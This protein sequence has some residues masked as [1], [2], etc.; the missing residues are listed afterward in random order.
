MYHLP[1]GVGG[2]RPLKSITAILLAAA[3]LPRAAI[4]QQQHADPH[5]R[6][7]LRRAA[8]AGS[9]PIVLVDSAHRNFH[10]LDGG[11]APFGLLLQADGYQ[12]RAGTTAFSAQ[13][14]AGIDLLVIANARSTGSA[15]SAFTPD[16]IAAVR[17]WV[18]DGGSLL[19]IADHAPFGTA[20][21]AMA[22][23]FGVSL[24]TGFAVVRQNGKTTANIE[25]RGR[26][27][28]D[29]PILQG[30]DASERVKAVKSFTGKSMSIPAD[31][32]GLL[33][34]PSDAL[35][36][37]KEADIEALSHGGTVPGMHIGGRAQAIASD[38]GRGRIVVAGEAAMFSEQILP[39]GDRVGLNS[40][41]DQQFVLNLVHWLSRLI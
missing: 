28:G 33:L 17:T 38:F 20:A 6:P 16:E 3:L 31:A 40:D 19:L 30:R 34:L 13:S 41:D 2:A 11:Y 23:A 7:R 18:E 29:H 5:F 22:A 10:T 9:G 36:V 25:F 14:L 35:G 1:E 39:W 24:D 27:L 32:T 37:L 21:R 12:L 8:Y 15:D 26:L 4:A